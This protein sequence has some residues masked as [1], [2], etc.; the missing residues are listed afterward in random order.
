MMKRRVKIVCSI[1]CLILSFLLEGCI[2]LYTGRW[3]SVNL[4]GA[5]NNVE[6]KRP[7]KQQVLDDKGQWRYHTRVWKKGERYIVEVPVAFVPFNPPLIEH[8]AGHRRAEKSLDNRYWGPSEEEIAQYPTELYYA[9]LSHRQF[10]HLCKPRK[11]DLFRNPFPG[12]KLTPASEM[13]FSGATLILDTNGAN[14]SVKNEEM[15]QFSR[16]PNLLI[17][18]THSIPPRRSTLNYCLQP[19]CWVAEVVDIPLTLIATPIGWVVDAIYEPL[20]N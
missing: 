16:I 8:S 1:S 9:D 10:K 5:L 17:I 4:G 11:S 2:S 7:C 14:V 3:T 13:D 20:H 18:R 19:I 12:V 15:N 6:H